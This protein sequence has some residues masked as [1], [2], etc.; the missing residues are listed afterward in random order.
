MKKY[1]GI[2][3]GG[4][5]VKAALVGEDGA[6][7][8]RS[9]IPTQ[10]TR[11][12]AQVAADIA[13]QIAELRGDDKIEGVGIGCPGSIDSGRGVVVFS[14]NLYW[15][16]VPLAEELHRLTGERVRVCNDANAAALG[17]TR[18]GA[19]KA[20]TDTVLITLGT[21]VGSG[22]VIGGKLFEGYRG[23]GAEAGHTVIHTD[24]VPCTCGRKGCLES[25]ASA[26]ALIRETTF[27]MQTDRN[28]K[29]WE[30]VDGD[31]NKVDGRTSFECAKKGDAAAKRVVE[32]YILDL[33]EGIA[34]IVN[35]FRSQAVILGGGVCAQ[36]KYLTEPLQ[37]AV[38]ERC[39]FVGEEF[40][41]KIVIAS[42]G[43][44]AGIVGAASLV[45]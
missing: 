1:I 5:T 31:L 13:T 9:T 27:A 21:G 17:E 12:F 19:G 40:V 7:V 8:R 3:I 41:T 44:D 10:A 35:I 14:N 4:T 25:Y 43:N 28:S 33:A 26:T 38:N 16:N 29:M 42:L 36:G 34:N 45:M 30:F 23:M 24:G 15:N 20:Y 6:I 22:F 11:P 2:D 39:Y 37:K 32:K 18:F